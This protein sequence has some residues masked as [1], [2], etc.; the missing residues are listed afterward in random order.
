M[1]EDVH[2][3]IS[4]YIKVYSHLKRRY[5]FPGVCHTC[6]LSTETSMSLPGFVYVVHMNHMQGNQNS[7]LCLKRKKTYKSRSLWNNTWPFL[8]SQDAVQTEEC[9]TWRSPFYESK[10]WANLM[11]VSLCFAQIMCAMSVFCVH[12]GLCS[13]AK[14]CRLQDVLRWTNCTPRLHYS[15]NCTSLE[16]H[17]DSY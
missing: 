5:I 6:Q 4:Q 14:G 16:T 7:P 12:V 1:R 8:S 13:Q 10:W 11:K 17:V 15:L 9:R 2:S 3:D